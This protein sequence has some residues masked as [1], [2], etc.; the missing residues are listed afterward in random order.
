[1]EKQTLLTSRRLLVEQRTQ[2]I[3]CIRGLLKTQGKLDCGSSQNERKFIE[4][5]LNALKGL[6]E[7]TDL[8][9]NALLNTYK[10][11]CEG[12]SKIIQDYSWGGCCNSFNIQA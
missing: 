9:I 10:V 12:V 8:S 4:S 2:I 1:M 7:D 11:I 3:N 6:N 5:V